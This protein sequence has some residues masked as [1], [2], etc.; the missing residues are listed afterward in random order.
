MGYLG[1]Q[2]LVADDEYGTNLRN[3]DWW[4]YTLNSPLSTP[5]YTG[6]RLVAIG[7]RPTNNGR[8]GLGHNSRKMTESKEELVAAAIN[9]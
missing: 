4:N 8:Y 6:D 3:G 7:A 5:F 2:A 1:N 9:E